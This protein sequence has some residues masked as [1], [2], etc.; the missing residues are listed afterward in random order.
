MHIKTENANLPE[1]NVHSIPPSTISSQPWWWR[2]VGYNTISPAVLGEN[3]SKSSSLE[4]SNSCVGIKA[5]QIHA[6]GGLDEEADVNKEMQTTEAQQSEPNVHSIPPSTISSQPW[7]WRGVGYNTISPAVLGENASKSS[8]LEH[9]NSCVGIKASQIHANGGLDVEADVN[10]EMHTTEVQQSGSDYGQQNQHLQHVASKTPSTMGEYL[11]PPT[12]LELVGHSIAYAPYPYSNSYY[13]GIKTAYG[14]QAVVHPHL[15]GM[16]QTRMPLPL[17]MEEEPV[18]VNAKQYH[19]ILRRRQ[20]RAKAELEKKLIKPRKPYI[21][22]SRHQHAMKRP[23]GCGGRFVNTK[24]LDSNDANPTPEKL[25]TQSATASV[26]G[27]LPSDCTLNLDSS[28]GKKEPLVQDT[29]EAHKYSNNNGNDN[30]C[31]QHHQGFQLSKYRSLSGE[32]GEEGDCSGQQRGS[33]PV[34]RAP[35]RALTIQ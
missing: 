5:G 19:G 25:S 27:P 6:N 32:R 7:W 13:G 11:T 35:H 2:G 30:I 24:K 1:P 26:S 15:P 17:E 8:S 9:S 33:I 31:H 23:R 16:H 12:Q 14:H 29:L 22:E 34:N 21:H 3:A 10:K 28:N 18:Y 20:T 4:H